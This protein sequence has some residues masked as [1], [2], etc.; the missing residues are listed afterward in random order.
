VA[1]DVDQGD[2]DWDVSA[3]FGTGFGTSTGTGTA[4]LCDDNDMGI[5]PDQSGAVH[6]EIMKWSVYVWQRQNHATHHS[7]IDIVMTIK[8]E[9]SRPQRPTRLFSIRKN[10]AKLAPRPTTVVMTL[11]TSGVLDPAIWKK[12]ADVSEIRPESF[13]EVR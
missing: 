4:R 9:K 7:R 1:D 8:P 3:G 12:S 6:K 10:V 5:K 11:L 2:G 13:K